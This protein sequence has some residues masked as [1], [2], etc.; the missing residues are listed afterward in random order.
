MKV[1]PIKANL[2]ESMNTH[3]PLETTHT[4]MNCLF[5]IINE[6][7]FAACFTTFFWWNTTWHGESWI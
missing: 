7:Q 5:Q 1:L 4:H 3:F 6:C 2:F